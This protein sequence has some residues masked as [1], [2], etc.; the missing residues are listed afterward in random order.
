LLGVLT[1]SVSEPSNPLRLSTP[2]TRVLPSRL[3]PANTL[4]SP[5]ALGVSS[6]NASKPCERAGMRPLIVHHTLHGPD[7]S[8]LVGLLKS[9]H[10][11]Q[12]PVLTSDAHAERQ[13]HQ[14]QADLVI[15]YFSP[16]HSERDLEVIRRLRPIVTG[17][18]L[19][20]G[21]VTDPKLILRAMQAGADLFLDQAE[22][23]TELAAAFGRLRVKQE[24]NA[25]AGRLL[26]VLSASGGCGASTLAVN[27]AASLAKEHGHCGLVDLNPGRGDLAALLDLKP[28]YTLAD[29]CRN[30]ARLDRAMFER[31]LVH[32]PSGIVLLG[33]AQH[34]EDVRA[35]TARGI[36]QALALCRKLFSQ[37]VVDLEDC[38]HEEQVVALEQATGVLIICRLDFTALRNARRIL[39]HLGKAGVPRGRVRVVVNQHGQPNEVPVD[40]AEDALGE[41][42]AH[43]IP[44]D[45]KVINT[46]NN[47]GVPVV[48]KDPHHKFVQAIG[49]LTNSDFGKRTGSSG[50]FPRIRLL[51]AGR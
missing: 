1:H 5:A 42:L 7:L 2:P 45:P 30:E 24:T 37:V 29:L 34:F 41:K 43:F 9:Q 3:P 17:H 21:E 40:A 19:A 6:L 48:L 36:S 32:H 4:N 25:P 51:F 50:I 31:M 33:A 26:A 46:A 16:V 14:S 47:T 28:Q 18:I 22:L 23:E 15:A 13:Y 39:D 38:F 49:H 35:T 44:H 11:C 10:N 12:D 20:V 27:I 8:N